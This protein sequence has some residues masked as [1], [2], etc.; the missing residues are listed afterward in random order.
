MRSDN[1]KRYAS[2]Y[3]GLGAIGDG[4]RLTDFAAEAFV[5]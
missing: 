4:I 1:F 5:P 3:A 2:G